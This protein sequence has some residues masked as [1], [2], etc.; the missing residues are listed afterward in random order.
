MYLKL[1]VDPIGWLTSPWLSLS[2]S[3]SESDC[4]PSRLDWC[5]EPELSCSFIATFSSTEALGSSS[6][7]KLESRASAGEEWVSDADKW[8]F[9]GEL[10]SLESSGDEWGESAGEELDGNCEIQFL[11]SKACAG[12]EWIGDVDEWAVKGELL[13]MDSNGNKWGSTGEESDGDCEIQSLESKACSG[14]EWVGDVEVDV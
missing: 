2:S 6:F 14:E 4:F 10:L 11:E 5:S 1:S 3:F 8:A 12:E 13:S 9:E 7:D